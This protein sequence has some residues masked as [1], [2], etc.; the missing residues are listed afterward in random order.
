MSLG[1]DGGRRAEVLGVNAEDIGAHVRR[2]HA[3]QP[4]RQPEAV[5]AGWAAPRVRICLPPAKSHRTFGTARSG[6]PVVLDDL[7][8]ML[9][10]AREWESVAF[11]DL[12]AGMQFERAEVEDTARRGFE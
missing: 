9:Q 10:D 7:M 4:A 5:A 3:P 2:P 8:R 6:P 12:R 1:A 11:G